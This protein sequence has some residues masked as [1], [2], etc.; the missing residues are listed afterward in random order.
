MSKVIAQTEMPKDAKPYEQRFFDQHSVKI[1]DQT[2]EPSQ[3]HP[4]LVQCA[5]GHQGRFYKLED[6]K[7]HVY[8]H[9]GLS[10]CEVNTN[11][12]K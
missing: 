9:S 1:L 5:C 6:A 4:F 11:G 12:N 3:F 2:D 8:K 10:V 7:K